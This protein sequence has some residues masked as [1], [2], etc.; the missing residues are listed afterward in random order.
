M[1]NIDQYNTLCIIVTFNPNKHFLHNIN[2][3]LNIFNKI[4]VIDNNSENDHF[5]QFKFSYAN[6]E[7]IKINQLKEN[8]GIAKALNLGVNFALE[9]NFEY[10]VSF[11]Q[12][13]TPHINFFKYYNYV[14][15]SN[16]Y[17]NIGIIGCSFSSNN[18]P[19]DYDNI[20]H[21]KSISLITSGSIYTSRIFNYVGLFNEDLFI[22][23]VDFDFN[24]RV[25]KEKFDVVLIEQPLIKHFI[26]SRKTLNLFLFRISSTNHNF[27]RRYYMSRN[28]TYLT[29]KYFSAF[30]FWFLKKN[31]FYIK[32][33]I[34]ML[35]IDSMKLKKIEYSI[36][37]V[38][39]GI[40][41]FLNE[42]SR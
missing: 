37:G 29:L 23:G 15:E 28:H 39:D 36:K 11:D 7:K 20:L 31:V 9:N 19:L 14:I 32:S 10:I 3:H 26:G 21:S 4:L 13:S 34:E 41:Y 25:I 40:K 8:Y 16:L 1:I 22:D 42:K 33:I 17:K 18:L 38:I 6:N 2:V 5:E 27:I 24:L 30:P 35:L 12:D